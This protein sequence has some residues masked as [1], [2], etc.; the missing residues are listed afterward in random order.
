M[1][2]REQMTQETMGGAGVSEANGVPPEL[3]ACGP[4]PWLQDKI[5]AG[6]QSLDF[7]VS[8]F[9][10]TTKK[11]MTSSLLD[12]L[13]TLRFSQEANPLK[14]VADAEGAAPVKTIV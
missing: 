3:A 13:V 8:P 5:E 9:S 7:L 14:S 12:F 6:Y 2:L 1:F 4:E 11:R 10:I